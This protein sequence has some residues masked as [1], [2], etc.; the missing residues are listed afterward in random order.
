MSNAIIYN[1]SKVERRRFAIKQRRRRMARTIT[2]IKSQRTSN[3]SIMFIS[4]TS[5]FLSGVQCVCV[6]VCVG[7]CGRDK[8]GGGVI[9]RNVYVQNTQS[10]GAPDFELIT[11]QTFP[12]FRRHV[13]L[14][15]CQV[16]CCP[17]RR[18]PRPYHS[19]V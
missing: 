12:L 19:N 15:R 13:S 8:G 2:H 14:S 17:T 6:C 1:Y 7:V 4:V 9:R 18:G 3:Y 10:K 11:G 5:R 16:G